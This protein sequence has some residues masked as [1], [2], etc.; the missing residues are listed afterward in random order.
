MCDD[1]ASLTLN[2]GIVPLV[3]EPGDD[4]VALTVRLLSDPASLR[5]PGSSVPVETREPSRGL[6]KEA[7]GRTV[8]SYD[9]PVNE[10]IVI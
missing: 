6:E 7:T 5:R 9:R 8:P 1:G 2:F 3:Q 10:Q 4:D